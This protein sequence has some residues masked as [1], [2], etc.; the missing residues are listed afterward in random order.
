[1]HSRHVIFA[2]FIGK[3]G[4][5]LAVTL[6]LL[7]ARPRSAMAQR[8]PRRP[9]LVVV[10]V[11]D[12]LRADYLSRYR[13]EFGE[14]GF[15][16][17]MN[18]GAYFPN[19]YVAYGVSNT[20]PGHAS[21]V[22]GRYP[23]Q[24][25]IIANEWVQGDGDRSLRG[26]FYDA[27]AKIITGPGGKTEGRS[28]RNLVG[29]ALGDELKLASFGS[30]VFSVALK[31]RAAIAMGGKK[32]NG[33]FWW[34][35]NNGFFVTSEYYMKEV[36]AYVREF[37]TQRW[38]DRF[39]DKRWDR[40]LSPGAYDD[41]YP[42]DAKWLTSTDGL[43]SAFPHF[44]P[45][46]DGKPGRE[47][48][49]AVFA[50]PFG[51]DVVLEMARRILTVER[52]GS[53]EAPDLL[54]VSL[55]SFDA[56]GHLFGPDS[57][58]MK[59]FALRTDRQIAA[60]LE[61]L[62]RSV[63]LNRCL[64]VLTADHGITTAP[65]V[66]VAQGLGGGR[67][68][69]AAVVR[70]LNEKLSAVAPLPGNREYVTTT[71]MPWIF[72]DP[73]ISVLD[74]QVRAQVMATA[75]QVLRGVEGIADVFAGTELSGN[76]PAS[77]DAFQRRLAWRSYYPGRSGDIY[78]QLAPYWNIKGGDFAEHG[79]CYNQD[80]HVPILMMG[81]G[82]LPGRYLAE[83]GLEDIPVTIAAVLGIEPPME[84]VG[85]VLSEAFDPAA[86]SRR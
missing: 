19:T 63:G 25:G 23:R 83:A 51:N 86:D 67:I 45:R 10:I 13:S 52:L 3:L 57:A 65:R 21:I 1:M 11:V 78:V 37:N 74:S 55:S 32:P 27:D 46:P 49:T 70:T 18:N 50:S 71:H 40:L 79:T 30:R 58:E 8:E 7:G 4:L 16:R 39:V 24:H 82:A 76:P 35:V 28:P 15:R 53:D 41:T 68:D 26:A 20:G 73:S 5:A 38:A 31:D 48:Y 17:M 9:Q 60:F 56:A 34:D 6:V 64:V 47:F 22:T 12:Q 75:K 72:L 62:D 81:G 2:R 29:T 36:P 42:L 77:A 69:M 43:G 61:L 14:G 44:M 84:A 85:R 59:D 54:C 80:R 66:A 33:V